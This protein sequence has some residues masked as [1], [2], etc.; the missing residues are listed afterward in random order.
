MIKRIKKG[1]V[2]TSNENLILQILGRGGRQQLIVCSV[3]D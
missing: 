2:I 1:A 3:E